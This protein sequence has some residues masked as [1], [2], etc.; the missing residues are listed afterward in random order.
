M[1]RIIF[2][3]IIL[4]LFCPIT[5]TREYI[6][7]EGDLLRITVYGHRDMETITRI[8]GTGK[9]TFPLI[10][11]V[12]AGGLTIPEIKKKIEDLLSDGYLINPS[13]SILIEE[14]KSKKVVVVGEV[15]RPGM[16]ELSGDA[17]LLE[18]L[19]KV[20]GITEN[21]GDVLYLQ[22]MKNK[23]GASEDKETITVDLRMLLE[24]R[25]QSINISVQEEDSIYI[26]RAT[27]FYVNGEVRRP[28]SYRLTKG[29][30]VLKAV[31]IAG[32]FT[33]K[34]SKRKVKI[35]RNKDGEEITLKAKASDLIL[36][37][38]VIFVPESF[39]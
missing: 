7:G 37:E 24:G 19:S 25:D 32:G 28:G 6:V 21:A 38:D 36:P 23:A 16:V 17:T 33:G 29:L 26:S 34:A 27:F 8:S 15:N 12:M 13:V 22:R 5:Y 11:E 39:F 4:F 20:G 10:G 1:K 30:T 2:T 3:V 14:F 31:T 18:V 35:I 9:I